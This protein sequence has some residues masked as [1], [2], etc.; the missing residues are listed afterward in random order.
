MV[1]ADCER[2]QNAKMMGLS[3]MSLFH[4]PM[5]EQ[6]L[7]FGRMYKRNT[8]N[9]SAPDWRVIAGARCKNFNEHACAAFDGRNY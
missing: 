1:G 8:E 3:L 5:Y 2:F 6:F 7:L 4:Q 9:K